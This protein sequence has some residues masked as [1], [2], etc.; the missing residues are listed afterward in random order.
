MRPHK[1]GAS[2]ASTGPAPVTA[3]R[4]PFKKPKA[5]VHLSTETAKR[6]AAGSHRTTPRFPIRTS[7]AAAWA[8]F[9]LVVGVILIAACVVLT[10]GWPS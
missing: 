8:L 1:D 6:N 5:F 9:T 2:P 10:L 4:T 3:P 7:N